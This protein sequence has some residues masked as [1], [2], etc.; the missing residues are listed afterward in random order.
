MLQFQIQSHTLYLFPWKVLHRILKR[1]GGLGSDTTSS[2]YFKSSSTMVI[3]PSPPNH[4][5]EYCG[6]VTTPIRFLFSKLLYSIVV[7]LLC[8]NKDA[9]YGYHNVAIVCRVLQISVSSII[10]YLFNFSL[11]FLRFCYSWSRYLF[12]TISFIV[13]LICMVDEDMDW[14][15]TICIISQDKRLCLAE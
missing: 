8:G 10:L 12:L 14:G 11:Y 1:G 5:G 4:P 6:F 2:Y 7:I 9:N 13:L 3:T 15:S